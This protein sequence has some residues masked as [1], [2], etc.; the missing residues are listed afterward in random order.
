MPFNVKHAAPSNRRPARIDCSGFSL[1]EVVLALGVT[2]FCIVAL[3]GLFSIGINTGKEST[4][5][6]HAAHLAQTL[7]ATRKNAPDGF[8]GTDFPLPPLQ[9]GAEPNVRTESLY[10]DS[11][12]KKTT[13]SGKPPRYGFYYR[14]DNPGPGSHAPLK[15]YISL[16]WPPA[17]TPAKA[18]GH[19]EVLTYASLP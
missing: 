18:S 13:V 6:L 17:D 2:A 15:V 12:G 19:Y 14:I 3:L 8:L 11:D 7:L 9:R 16:F 1:I 4:E 10:L 5:E